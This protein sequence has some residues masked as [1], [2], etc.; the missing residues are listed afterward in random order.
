LNEDVSFI[1]AQSQGLQVQTANQKLL[2]NELQQ[3]VETISITDNQLEPL[4]RER[5]GKVD[6]LKAIESSLVLLYKA[7]MTIDPAIIE[8]NK[9]AAGDMSKVSSNS[10][11]GNS[12]LASMQALQEKKDRYLKES[13][14]FLD[15]L[16]Q[17]MT[18][19]FGAAFIQTKDV[20]STID[21]SGTPSL[22][23]NI[24]AHDA[25]RK[26][27]WM[28]SPLVLFAK[29][30]DRACWLEMVR[31]Y[32]KEAGQ[33]YQEEVRDNVIAWKKLARKPTAEE[34][35]LLFTAQEKE[36]ETITG[37]ARKLT[38][39]RS[40]TLARGLRAASGEKET[41]AARAQT[42]KLHTFDVFGKVLD[43]VSPL[44][45]TEQN[46]ITDFFHATSTHAVDFPDAVSAAP[47]E[48][49]RSTNLWQRKPFEADRVMAKCVAEVMEDVFSFWPTEIQNLVEWSVS[50]DPL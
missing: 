10:G 47:P 7:L 43:D 14:V 34:Q 46:F 40:Q 8:D 39:K 17:H 32:R 6:G 44:L 28:F 22:R 16:K 5:I 4:R 1:E 33:V 24:D 13:A 37:T 23:S 18:I 21:R 49:R 41:K 11:F 20:L 31:M 25:G 35:D 2:Q 12:E 30:I 15:R 48:A 45:L 27:L 26:Q 9:G 38:V 36:A 19:T 50:G 29:E 42:G 3:L